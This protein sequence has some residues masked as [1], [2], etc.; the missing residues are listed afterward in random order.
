MNKQEFIKKLK[1]RL[2]D[3]PEEDLK[4]IIYD[5]NEFIDEGVMEGKTEEDIIR[6]LGDPE[7]LSEQFKE[8][9]ENPS[10][11]PAER[12]PERRND[13]IVNDNRFPASVIEHINLRTRSEKIQFEYQDSSDIHI[14][15]T[16]KDGEKHLIECYM[17][18][19]T[20]NIATKDRK[21]KHRFF[22][23]FR[24][25]EE[26]VIITVILPRDWNK[27]ISSHS[28][29]SDIN[30]RDIVFRNLRVKNVSGDLKC[31]TITCEQI[32]FKSVSGDIKCTTLT[33]NR[34]TFKS[35]SGDIACDTLKCSEISFGSV[36]GDIKTTAQ[37]ESIKFHSVSGDL[38]VTFQNIPDNIIFKSTSGD[39]KLRLPAKSGIQGKFKTF[40][41]DLSS[42]FKINSK[43]S[44][45][46]NMAF[47]RDG[48]K[49][50]HIKANTLSGDITLGIADGGE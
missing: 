50:V 34:I 3:I 18:D 20:L 2:S 4:E 32:D 30:S 26:Q 47:S 48:E 22:D 15:I 33:S 29:N 12:S 24:S 37:T 10:P 1:D 7:E 44:S 16:R 8:L 45:K 40:S 35:T 5:Y 14:N 39:L 25:E 19:N 17:T 42:D 6:E 21:K 28:V 23:L 31:D 49:I 11:I 13:Q 43:N 46:K 38:K 36:S 9:A 27:D 41:G